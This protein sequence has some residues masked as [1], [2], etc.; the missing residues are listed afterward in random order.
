M[1][2]ITMCLTSYCPR[3]E[4]C[5]RAQAIPYHHRQSF[6]DFKEDC[7]TNKYRNYIKKE[8]KK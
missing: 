4:H 2:D 6:A 5:Y 7:K 8:D 1:P 3:K